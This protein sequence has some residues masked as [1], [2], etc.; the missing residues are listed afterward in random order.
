MKLTDKISIPVFEY[1]KS[2]KELLQMRKEKLNLVNF[3]TSSLEQFKSLEDNR[4]D[5]IISQ[6]KVTDLSIILYIPI[7]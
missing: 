3:K 5:L 2:N 7:N 6:D 4:K 1:E